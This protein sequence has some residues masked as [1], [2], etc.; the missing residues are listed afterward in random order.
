MAN[1]VFDSWKLRSGITPGVDVAAATL[2]VIIISTN[3]TALSQLSATTLAGITTLDEYVGTGYTSG[4]VTL[5]NI[6]TGIDATNHRA[7]LDAD[8]ATWAA[9]GAG[10][11]S[12]LGFLLVEWTGTLAGSRPI[13]FFDN[14]FQ[15]NGSPVTLEF[16]ALG[17]MLQS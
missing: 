12:A 17:V 15:G 16:S 10:T 8:D 6:T 5:A 14:P 1:T 9:V 2:R 4:G 3:S 11:R 13:G 7:F